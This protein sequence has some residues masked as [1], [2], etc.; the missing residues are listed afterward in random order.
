MRIFLLVII[1]IILIILF[2]LTTRFHKFECLKDMSNKT[3]SWLI[4]ILIVIFCGSLFFVFG[5]TI[6]VYLI[7]LALFFVLGD[8]LYIFLKKKNIKYTTIGIIVIVVTTSYITYAW[9]NAM[10]VKETIYLVDTEKKTD[11]VDLIF[12][13]DSHFGTTINGKDFAN[14]I[15]EISKDSPDLIIV[16]GDFVDESTSYEDMSDACEAL[17]NA[18]T[19]YGVYMIFG[20]H[21]LNTYGGNRNYSS[22]EFIA[23]LSE[24]N[25]KI[26][27]D[28][29]SLINDEIY[30]IGRKDRT[31]VDRMS[32]TDLTKN[33]DK[34]KLIV[35]ADHQPVDYENNK[36]AGVDLVLSGHT[37]GGQ[38]FPLAYI[39]ELISENEMTYGMEKQN[40]TTFVVSSGISGWG[41]PLKTGTI[42]EYVHIKIK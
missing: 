20:N 23:K 26:L 25:V 5:L 31:V 17:G 40:N 27:Q 18:K 22:E 38:M 19:K 34:S 41:I 30:I 33:L 21:D 3:L 4:A 15:E 16:G 9:F 1:S 29:V 11:E 36:K 2:Y 28:E 14:Y 39:G 6:I 10:N 8:I 42:S 12:I 24:N 35:V 32:I 37:H 7:H 13:S